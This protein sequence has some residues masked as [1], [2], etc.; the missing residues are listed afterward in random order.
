M[1]LSNGKCDR[2][3]HTLKYQNTLY[4]L[5]IWHA[6]ECTQFKIQIRSPCTA[7]GMVRTVNQN[8]EKVKEKNANPERR[9][10]EKEKRR[11]RQ[12][13]A[14]KL[15]FEWITLRNISANVTLLSHIFIFFFFFNIL[16]CVFSSFVCSGQ[17]CIGLVV[18]FFFCVLLCL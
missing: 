1:N 10:R 15:D 7:H 14:H 13:H 8:I 12:K 11:K 17:Y 6:Y 16:L 4:R 9:R 18:F 5:F 2:R 3:T